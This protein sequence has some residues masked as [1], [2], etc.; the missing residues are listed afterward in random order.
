MNKLNHHFFICNSFLTISSIRLP[1]SGRLYFVTLRTKP[2]SS[3][4]VHYFSID[5]EFQYEN[6]YSDFGPVNMAVLYRYYC[7]LNKKLKSPTLAKKKIVH[8]TSYDSKKRANAAFLIA[9]YSVIGLRKSPDDAYHILTNGNKPPF[10]PFRDA[11]YGPSTYNLTILHCL[12]ALKK[13]MDN[14]FV[15]FDTF[16]VDEYEYY[17]KV[18]NGDFNWI[19]PKK[20]LAFS[21]PHDKTTVENG[22]PLHAPEAYI[23]YFHKHNITFV[24]RLNKKI[25]DAKRFT[26]NGIDHK[27]LFFTDGSTPS[28]KIVNEFLRLCEK[29]VGAIAVHCKAG[30]GR[31]GTLL[32]CYL[33]KHYRF[34]ASEAIGWLRICRPGSVIGPQQHFL[35]EKQN[36]LWI[37]G[38]VFDVQNKKHESDPVEINKLTS[39][40]ETIKIEDTRISSSNTSRTYTPATPS[41]SQSLS[42]GDE[43]RRLK[44]QNHVRAATTGGV[45]N[46]DLRS[47]HTRGIT[48]PLRLK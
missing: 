38:E 12:K 35:E 6:F 16:D 31:T 42:Q 48:Q 45:R 34:T 23:S 9:A 28:D 2:R 30:L 4:G 13:G 15:S 21:G 5:H 32:G 39:G 22:Y 25:Y 27:D 43:L 20:F 10:L 11:S 37:E 47:L 36:L 44:S 1:I 19:I 33:M 17:E 40:V 29:N 14:G 26:N 7:K 3:T 8:Y 24:I 46:D 41:L 18:E